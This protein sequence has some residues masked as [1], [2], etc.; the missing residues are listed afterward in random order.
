MHMDQIVISHSFLLLSPPPPPPAP[1]PLSSLSPLSSL[2][3]FSFLLSPLFS[4]SS[5]SSL[6]SSLFLLSPLSSIS[7]LLSFISLLSPLSSISPLLSFFSLLSPLPLFLLNQVYFQLPRQFHHFSVSSLSS[8]IYLFSICLSPLSLLLLGNSFDP[9]LQ[10]SMCSRYLGN[11][12]GET[13]PNVINQVYLGSTT[14]CP[15]V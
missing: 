2:L 9:P 1:P 15:I 4:L 8:L 6:L 13:L 12:T 5:L 10:A 3:S 11:I 7:P 14:V